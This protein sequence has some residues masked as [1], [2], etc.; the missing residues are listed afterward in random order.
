MT[1]L[2]GHTNS[3]LTNEGLTL[4][5]TLIIIKGTMTGQYQLHPCLYS[6]N[7]LGTLELCL[8]LLP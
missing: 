7:H 3:I 6:N 4:K 1:G 5:I 2:D 8:P